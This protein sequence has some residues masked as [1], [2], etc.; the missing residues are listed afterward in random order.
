MDLFRISTFNFFFLQLLQLF[1]LSLLTLE[2]LN[3]VNKVIWHKKNQYTT[4]KN[5]QVV[6]IFHYS[7]VNYHSYTCN[8]MY[9]YILIL[10]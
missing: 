9:Y 3:L 2:D 6:M 8:H 5:S 4:V 7:A 10:N 1:T